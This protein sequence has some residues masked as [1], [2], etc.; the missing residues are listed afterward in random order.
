[1]TPSDATKG[2][3]RYRYYVTHQDELRPDAPSA[4]RLPAKDLENAVIDRLGKFY[5]TLSRSAACSVAK[6]MQQQL[7]PARSIWRRKQSNV[8]ACLLAGDRS[9]DDCSPA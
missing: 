7:S 9:A 3:I 8:W 4:W 6:P 1:V 5:P 2:K